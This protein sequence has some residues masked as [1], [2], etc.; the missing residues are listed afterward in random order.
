MTRGAHVQLFFQLIRLFFPFHTLTGR[1]PI[2]L[3]YRLI[4]DWVL[5]VVLRCE[6]KLWTVWFRVIN[7]HNIYT[8][9]KHS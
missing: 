7:S 9:G 6:T 4:K 5:V 8:K 2:P 3:R 1:S